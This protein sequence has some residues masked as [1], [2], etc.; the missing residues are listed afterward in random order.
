MQFLVGTRIGEAATAA[1]G[2]GNWPAPLNPDGVAR[3]I[4][5]VASGEKH[6]GVT[7]R[8]TGNG[9]EGT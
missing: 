7:L 1:Y 8:V 4:L 3:A 6:R 5:S 2:P 9:L